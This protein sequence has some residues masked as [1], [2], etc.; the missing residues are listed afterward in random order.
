[1]AASEPRF[2]RILLKL[3]GEALMGD[4]SFGIDPAILET[5]GREIHNL[6]EVEVKIAI[7]IGG[8]NIF[9][10]L[11]SSEY[12][13]GR[14]PADHMGMLATVINAIALGEALNNIGSQTRVMSAIDMHK[15]AEPYIRERA[16]SHLKKNRIVLVGA[17]TGNPFFSTDTAAALRAMEIQAEALLKATKVD[18]VYDSDPEKNPNSRFISRINYREVLQKNLQ[19]MDMTA[20][21]LAMAQ[22]LPIIV[23]N[24]RKEGNIKKV[25]F[26]DNVG[27]LI[28]GEAS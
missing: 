27:S 7:V 28:S 14:I 23:F 19:V 2:R 8:G 4:S 25:I 22:N 10:G 12:G 3:S 9:R 24:L 17:G 16:V 18:G 26:G 21:S 5:V 11:N 13:M 6:H 15:I 20:V 1:M